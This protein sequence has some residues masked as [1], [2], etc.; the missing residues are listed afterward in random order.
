MQFRGRGHGWTQARSLAR[1][2]AWCGGTP[3]A[4]Q[5]PGIGGGCASAAGRLAARRGGRRL[6]LLRAERV[7]RLGVALPRVSP[8]GVAG[9]RALSRAAGVPPFPRLSPPSPSYLPFLPIL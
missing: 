1:R 9:D 6:S 5:A 2:L 7:S 4:R 3:R 8:P